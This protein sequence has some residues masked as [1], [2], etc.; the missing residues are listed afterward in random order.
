MNKLTGIVFGPRPAPR[1]VVSVR[2]VE[3]HIPNLRRERLISVWTRD[4]T[5]NRLV[6]TW[7]RPAAADNLP[8][9]DAA[10]PPSCLQLAA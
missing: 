10:E 4:P 8:A 2:P 5:T 9:G 3:A 6:C 1:H 7:R